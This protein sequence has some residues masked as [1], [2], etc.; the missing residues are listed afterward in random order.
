[1]SDFFSPS[2][3]PPQVYLSNW[4][5]QL[6]QYKTPFVCMAV[7]CCI[8][9]RMSATPPPPKQ[10]IA[11]PPSLH[12]FLIFDLMLN[13]LFSH[14]FVIRH[15]IQEEHLSGMFPAIF[16]RYDIIVH[17]DIFVDKEE[18]KGIHSFCPAPR[19]SLQFS[20]VFTMR[21]FNC[22]LH[23]GTGYRYQHEEMKDAIL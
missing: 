20:Q 9:P 4:I 21:G 1:M 8:C 23:T 14:I 13:S 5:K 22:P 6:I 7:H 12:H 16:C 19:C 10:K 3:L 2:S 11:T 15:R 17:L 18:H